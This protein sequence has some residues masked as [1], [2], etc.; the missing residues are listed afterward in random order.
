MSGKYLCDFLTGGFSGSDLEIGQPSVYRGGR[1][2]ETCDF[3][4]GIVDSLS[5]EFWNT[6]GVDIGWPDGDST[7]GTERL[8]LLHYSPKFELIRAKSASSASCSSGPSAVSLIS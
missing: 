1:S 4:T 8:E 2:V 6:G 3:G 7:A 5:F